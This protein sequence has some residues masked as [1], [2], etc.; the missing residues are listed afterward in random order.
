MGS[1]IAS[2]MSVTERIRKIQEEEREKST[3][4]EVSRETYVT[5]L[6]RLANEDPRNI[7][8]QSQYV[9]IT[10]ECGVIETLQ[11]I[12]K[13]LL[14]GPADS[15]SILTRLASCDIFGPYDNSGNRKIIGHQDVFEH[16]LAWKQWSDRGSK[17][18][19]VDNIPQGYGV[20]SITVNLD[21]NT[22]SIT[23]GGMRSIKL[24]KN[25][26]SSNKKLIEDALVEAFLNPNYSGDGPGW[27]IN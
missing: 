6:A 15:H 10:E 13:N 11:E 1:T 7:F 4:A 8:I 19:V 20:Y 9:K 12:E 3:K 21:V 14:K 26:W 17:L 23:I 18:S 5:E 27:S 16:K 25:E 24:Q 22:E 2:K